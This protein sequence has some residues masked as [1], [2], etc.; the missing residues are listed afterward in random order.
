MSTPPTTY[1][2][3]FEILADVSRVF[4]AMTEPRHLRVWLSD[5][6]EVDP[7]VGGVF[8]FWGR[9]VPWMPR[10]SDADQIITRIDPPLLLGFAWTWRGCRGEAEI[11]LRQNEPKRT[12]LIVHHAVSGKLW[13]MECD[14]ASL[15]GD[16]WKLFVGNLRCYLQSGKPAIAPDYS[17]QYGEVTLS[18]EIN[19]PPER[20]FRALS[21]PATMDRWLSRA[22]RVEL[23]N[24]GQYSYGWTTKTQA[25]SSTPCGPTKLIEVI[26]NRMLLHD[27]QYGDEPA[28]RVRWDLEPL[29]KRTRVTI[30]HT[31]FDDQTM[32]GGYT[33]GWAAFLVG[34]KELSESDH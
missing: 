24:G 9:R 30:T 6:V 19:A 15:L 20:I 29:G 28:T 4:D 31:K 18:I 16:F 21:D 5:H 27:W 2:Q 17:K 14:A 12:Q 26:P 34:L 22:A 13:P 25:G 1:R 3:D 33:Q 11:Q 23:R 10:A 32:H 8:R 7:R